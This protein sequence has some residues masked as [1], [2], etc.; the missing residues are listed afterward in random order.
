MPYPPAPPPAAYP[1]F[2]PPQALAPA[3][4]RHRVLPVA[5]V[6]AA[7]VLALAAVAFGSG[8]GGDDPDDTDTVALPHVPKATVRAP[9]VVDGA[10]RVTSGPLLKMAQAIE[11]PGGP[12]GEFVSG[13]YAHGPT[14]RFVLV[15]SATQAPV[16]TMH[17]AFSAAARRNGV[18]V[19]SIRAVGNDLRCASAT[20]A[21]AETWV[22]FWSGP[23]SSGYVF[24]VHAGDLHDTARVTRLVRKEV[25]L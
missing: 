8:L 15:A 25:E 18:T 1:S 3:P 20:R 6:A 10:H 13:L 5:G 21:E 17:R 11:T 2:L 19:S 14:A 23:L 12:E 24:D 22:C 7:V 4:R 16:A 9:E